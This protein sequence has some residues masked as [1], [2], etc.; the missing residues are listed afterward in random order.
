MP[1][2]GGLPVSTRI[3]C[4]IWKNARTPLPSGSSPRTPRREFDASILVTLSNDAPLGAP[5]SVDRP[6]A[7]GAVAPVMRVRISSGY[8]RP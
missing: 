4:S 7:P 6:V 8:S 3:R 1:V 2:L 5:A